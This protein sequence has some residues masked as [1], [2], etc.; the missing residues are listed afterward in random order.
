MGASNEHLEVLSLLQV[1]VS[2]PFDACARRMEELEEPESPKEMS[3]QAIERRAL[4]L[5]R[6]FG[7]PAFI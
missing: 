1:L 5:S 4:Q 7:S 6:E 3:L 2:D